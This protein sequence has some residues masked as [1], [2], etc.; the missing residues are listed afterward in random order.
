MGNA[1]PSA[2][3]GDDFAEFDGIETL[4]YRVLGVQPNSPAS[5]AGLVSFF[6]FLVGV[7]GM[8]L[9][10]SGEGL[11]E[12]EEYNDIDFP[13]LLHEN[14][15]NV[16]EL[17]VWNIKAQ[18]KRLVEL[19]PN[20]DWDGAGLLGVTIKLDNYGGADERLIRVLDVE[21]G[22]PAA[23][24]GLVKEKDFML[25]TTTT[26]FNTSAILAAVL[27][28]YIDQVVEIYVYNSD[29]DMVRVVGLMPSFA[30]GGAGLLGAEVGTGYLHRLPNSCRSTIGQ[31]IERKVRWTNGDSGD[32]RE[33]G[34]AAM[35]EMEPHLEM[36]VEKDE[37][38]GYS[39]PED[40]TRQP[41]ELGTTEEPTV[42]TKNEKVADVS[43]SD[44][45]C[46]S[47]DDDRETTS[48]QNVTQPE[49]A[50]DFFSGPPPETGSDTA[51]SPTE[52]ASLPA[53]PKMNY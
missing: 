40:G 9:L 4:G 21:E 32:G 42:P 29:S 33:T 2:E 20:D 3:N 30:W 13:A 25:G 27:E 5:K 24:A 26:N 10:G 28:E 53:P 18:E 52:T 23:Q 34:N 11:E 14:K 35:V 45:K 15:G 17:L 22:S 38:T 7:N 8:M 12:G 48:D 50:A 41:H 16:I 1:P 19:T 36:E 51:I 39:N 47:N 44:F 46:R 6:D 43:Y 31:S 49:D 37:L